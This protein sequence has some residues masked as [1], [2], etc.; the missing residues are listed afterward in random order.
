MKEVSLSALA[1]PTSDNVLELYLDDNK[2]NSEALTLANLMLLARTLDARKAS[3][4]QAADVERIARMAAEEACL[5]QLLK[6]AAYN[7]V[8]DQRSAKIEA[9]HPGLKA[10]HMRRRAAVEAHDKET[11]LR[12]QMR[13][14]LVGDA[15]DAGDALRENRAAQRE[16]EAEKAANTADMNRIAGETL[17]PP[18]TTLRPRP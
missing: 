9:E 6:L 16:A 11:A 17:N 3:A 12:K 4:W 2:V 8:C 15:G 14:I 1:E 7:D 10:E 5:P 18:R 13:V